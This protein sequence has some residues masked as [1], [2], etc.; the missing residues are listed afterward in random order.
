[1][2]RRYRWRKKTGE[3]AARIMVDLLWDKLDVNLPETAISTLHRMGSQPN[4]GSYSR[5]RHYP[6]IVRLVSYKDQRTI[7]N[8]KKKLMGTGAGRPVL[9]ATGGAEEVDGTVPGS[10]HRTNE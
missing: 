6:I 5:K 3:D 10:K 7:Y 4:P 8:N 9:S 1:M 2:K